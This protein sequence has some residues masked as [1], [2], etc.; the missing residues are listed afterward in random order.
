MA[1]DRQRP[2]APRRTTS[3]RRVLLTALGFVLA[4][5]VYMALID[6]TSLPELYAGAAVA[7][8]GAVTFEAAL[9]QDRAEM[10][11]R[12][13]RLARA[14]RALALIPADI[15]RVSAAA[16]AQAGSPRAERGRLRAVPF[17][18]GS[19]TDSRDVGRRA[20]AEALGSLAPNTI[21]IGIDHERDL[22]LVH[23][24]AGGPGSET[25]DATR[26]G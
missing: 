14:W 5:G 20:A 13:R 21:V 7:L 26:M 18:H 19:D 8:L 24:L 2:S 10:R 23:Q 16:L 6:T 9:E 22:L 11:V 15:V 4:G 3:G 12:A 1:S 25:V 17:R